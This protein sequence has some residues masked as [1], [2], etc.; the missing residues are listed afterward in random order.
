MTSLFA[1]VYYLIECFACL[2]AIVV[3]YWKFVT[4]GSW[5]AVWN[6]ESGLLFEEEDS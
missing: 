5:T 4:I 6:K 2:A 1:Y 3:T